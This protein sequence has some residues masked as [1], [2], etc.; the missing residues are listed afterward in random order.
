MSNSLS[1][2]VLGSVVVID[3]FDSQQSVVGILSVLSSKKRINISTSES[4]LRKSIFGPNLPSLVPIPYI[5][6][7]SE[8]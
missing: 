4:T 6:L 1:K 8:S 5:L 3:T 7:N 2:V